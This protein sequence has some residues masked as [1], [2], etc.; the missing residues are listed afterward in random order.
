MK[1]MGD[2]IE[3]YNNPYIKFMDPL[4]VGKAIAQT[5]AGWMNHPVG[6]AEKMR[7]WFEGMTEL[8]LYFF[9][10]SMGLE[11]SKET[12]DARFKSDKWSSNLFFDMLKETYLFASNFMYEATLDAPD[13]PPHIKRKAA[14]WVE[15][16]FNAASPS[17]S[18]LTN[19]DAIQKMI[20][21]KG[22]SLMDG[23]KL[24]ME[25][26]KDND[27]SMVDKK[28]FKVGKNLATTP[29]KVVFRTD[30]FELIQYTPK[31]KQVREKPIMF[32][33]PWINKFYVLDLNEKKSMISYLLKQGFSVFLISWRNVP[34]EM[35]ETHFGD[36]LGRGIDR[37]Q[38]VVRNISGAESIHAVGY[39]IG[40][41]ALSSY[42]A[43]MNADPD[44]K[45]TKPISSWTL[46]ASL[47][48]FS[49]PG[50]IESFVDQDSYDMV[51]DEMEK[52]GF[53]DGAKMNSAFRMLRSN[54]LIWNFF[55]DSYL[56]GEKPKAFDLLF[57][58][59]DPTRLPEEMHR[60][61]LREFYVN[62]NLVKK[63]KL[64]LSGR[65]I[66]LSNV[67]QPLYD[68]ATVMDHITPWKECFKCDY[69]NGPVRQVLG[70][71]GHILGVVSP[72]VDP[73]KRSYWAGDVDHI[74]DPDL[75][76]DHQEEQKGSWWP[77]WVEWLNGNCGE[78]RPALKV[79]NK[80][81]QPLC[82][83]PG[84]YVVEP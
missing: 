19:P 40:G 41:T 66:D 30:L 78:M 49:K 77:D 25:D 3:L 70:S 18:L 2:R 65:K 9:R 5:Q 31:T 54:D 27:I 13:V 20:D 14:F 33:P 16:I 50:E 59:S 35:R 28:A 45:A 82:D 29:G 68:V 56:C 17:N 39:C 43:W 44:K 47:V 11:K 46:F 60:F 10:R 61:Y 72:P 74:R 26:M 1:W 42:M 21:T 75:W 37:A 48:D 12:K 57:W 67:E 36:Y 7:A 83:A 22:Q 38:Q 4:G 24:F 34:K 81:Y 79:G 52:E 53:L 63:N 84:E 80:K 64:T 69:I 73:P 76:L 23:L 6:S 51:C 15:Q 71:S 32:I 8:Q 55:V 58:N 62:N